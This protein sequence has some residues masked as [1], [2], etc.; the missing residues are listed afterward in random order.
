MNNLKNSLYYFGI[1]MI[2]VY[3]SIA[4]FLFFSDY[5]PSL[6]QPSRSILATIIMLYAAFKTYRIFANKRSQTLDEDK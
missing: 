2:F 5:E 3:V 1:A 4:M 6:K